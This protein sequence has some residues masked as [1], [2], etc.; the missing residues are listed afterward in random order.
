MTEA[1]TPPMPLEGGDYVQT[2]AGL[3]RV[4]TSTDPQPGKSAPAPEKPRP[5][6]SKPAAAAKAP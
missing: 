4:A 2:D 6:P 5:T 1:K 3:K